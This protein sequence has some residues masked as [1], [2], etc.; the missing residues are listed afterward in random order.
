MLYSNLGFGILGQILSM[1]ERTPLSELIRQEILSPLQM[2]ASGLN[3]SHNNQKYLA[4]GYTA[5]G[6]PVPYLSSGLFGGSWAMRASTKDMRAYLM[7]VL[8]A[9]TTSKKIHQAIQLSQKAYFN[10]PSES[11]QI[12]LGWLITPLNKIDVIKKLINQP[13]HYNFFPY[14]VQKIQEPIF[15]PN[16]LI[17]KTGAT[18]GFR[19]YIAVIP[20]K[21]TGI[22]IMINRFIPSNGALSNLANKILLQ[23]SRITI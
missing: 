3:I 21:H 6:K 23:E 22:V 2:N 7:A 5:L 12:G 15:N 17:G 19:A 18:D 20:A 8:G 10:M 13:D 9:E 1:K 11:M 14:M 16:A 4:Q